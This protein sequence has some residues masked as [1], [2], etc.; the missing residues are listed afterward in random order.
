MK[1]QRFFTAAPLWAAFALAALLWGCATS[2]GPATVSPITSP[3]SFKAQT[4]FVSSREVRVSAI[5]TVPETSGRVPLVVMAHGHGDTKDENGG[6]TAI[7]EELAR[8]G[9]AS[10]R[11][12][13]PGC[14]QS[15]EPFTENN[16]TNMLADVEACRL[17]AIAHADIDISRI[18]IL[19]HSMG[20]RVAILATSRARYRSL[21]L[22]APVATDGPSALYAYMGGEAAYKALEA[23]AQAEEHALFP[24]MFG[25]AQDLSLKWFQDNDAAQCIEAIADYT[26][27]ILFVYGTADS[28][29]AKSVVD[30]SAAAARKSSGVERVTIA[31]ADHGYGFYGGD[32]RLKTGTVNA[33]ASFFAKTLR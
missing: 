12:D 9:I 5:L 17:Y 13:F 22:I 4:V 31:G 20:G 26:G 11:M 19:G 24:V 10:I 15:S 32:P 2:S 16:L 25:G 33:I 6:F 30:E 8:R 23:K 29:I 3:C 28:I 21:A 1:K 7:A 18:G 27:P 14:G